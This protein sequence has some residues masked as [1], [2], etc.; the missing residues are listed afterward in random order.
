MDL[1]ELIGIRYA[2]SPKTLLIAIVSNR[3][4]VGVPVP[5]TNVVNM[6][7]ADSRRFQGDFHCTRPS[8][9]LRMSCGHVVGVA[10]QAV[11]CHLSVK[12]GGA[13]LSVIEPFQY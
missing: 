11:T 9:C 1:M 10:R 4:L 13:D 12:A 2:W 7:R 3:S 8:L 6:L 5:C